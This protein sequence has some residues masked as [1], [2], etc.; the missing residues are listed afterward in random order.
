MA[1]VKYENWEQARRTFYSEFEREVRK[2]E[3]K[4]LLTTLARISADSDEFSGMKQEWTQRPPWAISGIARQSILSSHRSDGLTIT[5]NGMARMFN[6][7]SKIEVESRERFDLHQF[8]ARTSF[9]QFPYQLS[10]KEDLS[11]VLAVLI[12]TPVQFKNMKTEADFDGLLGAPLSDVASSTLVLY[13]LARANHGR[14]SRSYIAQLALEVGSKLPSA[15]SMLATL[16][17]LSATVEDAR[18]DGLSLEQF[19]GGY[20]K[21]SYNPLT[22]TP[23]IRLNDDT[24]IAPQTF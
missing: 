2:Y 10:A 7:Y 21:Y 8:L 18:A 13:R 9:E 3:P 5:N 19:K 17:R 16:D 12:D 6:L 22:K 20:Q 15:E 23:F 14:V 1:T 24:Y 4:L 11:R